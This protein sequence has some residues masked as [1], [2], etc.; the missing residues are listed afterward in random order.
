[1][2]MKHKLPLGLNPFAPISDIAAYLAN[3][4][5]TITEST[6][7]LCSQSPAPGFV[8]VEPGNNVI[9]QFYNYE[10]ARAAFEERVKAGKPVQFFVDGELAGVA[11]MLRPLTDAETLVEGG[12]KP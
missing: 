2:M 9:F 11:N 8:V 7:R 6:M 10:A 4:S 12:V 5:L 1:M 3:P